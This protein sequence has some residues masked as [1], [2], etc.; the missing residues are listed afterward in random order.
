[1]SFQLQCP[2]CGIVTLL[3]KP[4]AHRQLT[5]VCGVTLEL[6]DESE[7]TAGAG[8]ADAVP[9]ATPS[10]A[11]VSAPAPETPAAETAPGRKSC[12][13]CGAVMPED[14]VLCTECGFNFRQRSKVKPGAAPARAAEVDPDVELRQMRRQRLIVLGVGGVLALIAGGIVYWLA[15]A[16]D[17]GISGKHPLGTTAAIEEHVAGFM[18]MEKESTPRP[19]PAGFGIAGTVVTYRDKVMEKESNGRFAESMILVYDADNEICG[20]SGTFHVW[21]S[22]IPGGGLSRVS[23]FLRSY[24]EE[25]G[26]PAAPSFKMKSKEEYGFRRQWETAEFAAAGVRAVWTRSQIDSMG[27]IASMDTISV[28]REGAN[29]TALQGAGGEAGEEGTN[30]PAAGKKKPAT[31]QAT[32][33]FSPDQ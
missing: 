14:N 22:A 23:S 29:P 17:Y 15:T 12:P 6:A 26:A 24:W 7:D 5:C 18:K 13:E 1:M 25:M 28:A 21:S 3:A 2:K 20:V 10:A 4:P 11:E 32:Q 30:A 9:T 31:P 16:K 8:P 19:A 27:L 33:D